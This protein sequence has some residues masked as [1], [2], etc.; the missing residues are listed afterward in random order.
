MAFIKI[1]LT[2]LHTETCFGSS[3]G[4][5]LDFD[6]L[7][8]ADHICHICYPTFS[9]ELRNMDQAFPAFSLRKKDKKEIV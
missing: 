3:E 7:T 5:D 9:P 8:F 6:P 4:Q 1:E 2:Y